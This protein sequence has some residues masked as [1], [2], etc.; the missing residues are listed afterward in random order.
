MLV[1]FNMTIESSNL[2][3]KKNKG[4]TIRDKRTVKCDIG[5]AHVIIE[6]SNMRKKKKKSH[7]M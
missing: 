7:Q 1:L 6:L 5:I 4:T 3:K 2:R